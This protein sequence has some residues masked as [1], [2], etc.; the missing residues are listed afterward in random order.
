MRVFGVYNKVGDSDDVVIERQG[1]SIL[2]RHEPAIAMPLSPFCLYMRMIDS[3]LYKNQ[4]FLVGRSQGVSR[5]VSP[6]LHHHP[7]SQQSLQDGA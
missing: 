4:I 3:P 5:F 6:G 1:F 7:V 2:D